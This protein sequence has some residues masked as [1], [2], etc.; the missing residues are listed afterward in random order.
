MLPEIRK[1][2]NKEEFESVRKAASED[3]DCMQFPTHVVLKNNEIAGGICLGGIPFVMFWN[4][5]KK[6]NAR[7]SMMITNNISSILDNTGIQNYFTACN[8]HSPYYGHMEKLGYK[9]VWP[10]NLFYK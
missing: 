1:I 5:T 3:N 4:H 10:T 8:S 7:D 9:P 6:I 2:K